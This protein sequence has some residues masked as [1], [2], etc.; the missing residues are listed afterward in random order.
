MK[1]KEDGFSMKMYKELNGSFNGVYKA[2]N[3]NF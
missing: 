1:Y 2:Q 3:D